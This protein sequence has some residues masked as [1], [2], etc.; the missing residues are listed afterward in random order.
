MSALEEKTSHGDFWDDAES[1]QKS[2]RRLKQITAIAKPWDSLLKEVEENL[3]LARLLEGEEGSDKEIAELMCLADGLEARLDRLELQ[4]MLSGE[5]DISNCFLYIHPGA[6]G[7]ES[8]DWAMMLMR[9]YVR[10]A[11]LRSFRVTEEDLQPG[12]EAG[13][14][15]VTLFIEGEYA[16]GYLKAESGVHRLVRISPF[17]A[18]KRRHTSFASVFASPEVDETI[19]LAIKESDLRID[20]FRSTG[21]G[22]QGVNTTDSA[23]RITHLPTHIVV[24]CQNER[25]Q[26][27]NLAIAMKVLRSR[28]YQYYREEKEKDLAAL[29]AGKKEIA[30]GSQ[31]RSYVFQPYTLVKDH[32]TRHEA[33]SIQKM[34]NGELL[35]EFIEA[36]LKQQMKTSGKKDSKVLSD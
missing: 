6:G 12:D 27:K 23:I 5:N 8:C 10:W 18:N 29:E 1:A 35:D 14:K 24:Q 2:L 28:L 32:R 26:H 34:M 21:P 4:S 13:I 30:W 36:F 16:Y 33:G 15:S 11:E 17:D 9:M 25:S 19:N 22:G 3:E 31:I 7:T 20:R